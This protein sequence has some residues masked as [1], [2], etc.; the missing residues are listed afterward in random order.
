MNQYHKLYTPQESAA[1]ERWWLL[2]QNNQLTV[3]VAC[4]MLTARE[5]KREKKTN[6]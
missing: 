5:D 3:Q 2:Y 1:C 6:K 4:N